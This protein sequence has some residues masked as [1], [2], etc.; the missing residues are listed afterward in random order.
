MRTRRIYP[1][2]IECNKKK[3]KDGDGA[4][5]S[6]LI[7]S[8]EKRGVTHP[9]FFAPM[10]VNALFFLSLCVSIHL[11]CVVAYCRGKS[12]WFSYVCNHNSTTSRWWTI[13]GGGRAGRRHYRHRVSHWHSLFLNIFFIWILFAICSRDKQRRIGPQSASFIIAES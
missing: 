6:R 12:R 13:R 5:F 2:V 10:K 7:E 4:G 3:T 11:L 8:V 9:V 1:S